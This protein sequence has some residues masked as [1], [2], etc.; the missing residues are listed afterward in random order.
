MPHTAD[1]CPVRA[2]KLNIQLSTYGLE[3]IE[4]RELILADFDICQRNGIGVDVQ[5]YPLHVIRALRA[6]DGITLTCFHLS[7]R[8][9]QSIL[10]KCGANSMPTEHLLTKVLRQT[11]PEW[12]RY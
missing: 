9:G 7:A 4:H 8:L 10:A 1:Q 6:S 5:R 11:D 2:E 3:L 12:C